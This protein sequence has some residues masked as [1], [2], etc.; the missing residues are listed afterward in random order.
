MEFTFSKVTTLSK[1]NFS[2]I[3]K[4]QDVYMCQVSN[5][6][7][8]KSN[9][10]KIYCEKCDSVFDSREKFEKHIEKHSAVSCESCPLDMA[11]QKFVNLFKRKK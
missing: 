1:I 10:N 6:S 4:Q 8:Y 9:V 5:V 2:L 11:V 3:G 7:M